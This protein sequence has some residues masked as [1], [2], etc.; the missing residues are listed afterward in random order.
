MEQYYK[1]FALS[2]V[3]PAQ[4]KNEE[5]ANLYLAPHKESKFE[6]PRVLAWLPNAVQ[7][8]DLCKMPED[9]GYIYFLVLVEL[10]CRRVDGEPIKDKESTTVL[11]AFKAIYRRGRIIPPT[12]KIEVD[13][14]LEFN[15][16]LVRTFFT[17]T[18]GVLIRFGQPGRHRQQCY[19]ERAIQAIQKP[20]IQRMVAQEMLTGQESTEWV[21]D[22]Y[23]TVNAVDR[24]WR[25]DPPSV[26]L[27]S[28]KISINEELLPEGTQVRVKLEDP[29]TVLG[30]KLHGRFRTGD[31]RWHPEIRTIKKLTL[32]PGQPPM[33][34]LNGPH[35][36][37][38]VSRCAYTRKQLQV[39]PENEKAPPDSVIRGDPKYYVP[40]KIL[41]QRI[42]K[43]KLEYLIKWKR[44]P[45]N[46]ATWEPAKK[47]KE[48]A[49]GLVDF[50]KMGDHR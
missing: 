32:S 46:R 11:K 25:R 7:Q 14:G 17:Y 21:D 26:C 1:L 20:L 37:L 36:R 5:H 6:R 33:Y 9:R 15:N 8:A 29:I 18:V 22:F 19:A 16:W 39:V 24:K 30:K 40:E 41:K 27:D 47:I 12:H 44:Y 50:F 43:G 42:R 45:E 28:P 35:G 48:D 3:P 23:E 4:L 10:A 34:L 13:S 31:I 38:G 49:P 2:G